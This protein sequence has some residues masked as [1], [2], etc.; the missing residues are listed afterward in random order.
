MKDELI[1][2]KNIFIKEWGKFDEYSYMPNAYGGIDVF[3][4]YLVH[5]M[6]LII[7]AHEQGYLK[8]R[9]DRLISIRKERK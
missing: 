5:F 4:P 8:N 9:I 1:D 6:E 3:E 2:L 7:C